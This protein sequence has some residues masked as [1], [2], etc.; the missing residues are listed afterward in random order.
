MFTKHLR[1]LYGFFENHRDIIF[2]LM[3]RVFFVLFIFAVLCAMPQHAFAARLFLSP[4]SQTI[5]P[6]QTISVSVILSSADQA[7]NAVSGTISFPT[8]KFQVVSAS[9][10]GSV[11]SLWVEEPTYSNSAGT[12]NFQGIVPNPGYQGSRGNVLTI[13]FRATNAGPASISFDQASVLAND[14]SGTDI[15]SDKQGANFTISGATP[16]EDTKPVVTPK[17]TGVPDAPIVSSKSHPSTTKWYSATTADFY[18]DMPEDVTAVRY[19]LD[20]NSKVTPSTNGKAGDEKVSFD[21]VDEGVWFFNIQFKN[22][23]GWGSIGSFRIR[24][25]TTPPT[26]P[27]FTLIDNSSDRKSP[28]ITIRS[29]DELSG[30]S[31]YRVKLG[32]NKYE[33][34]A[35]SDDTGEMVVPAKKPGEQTVIVEAY[36]QAGNKS[37]AA[38]ELNVVTMDAPTITDAPKI[39]EKGQDLV[40]HGTTYPDMEVRVYMVGSDGKEVF[41]STRSGSAGDFTLIWKDNLADGSYKV[42]AI[43]VNS[44]GVESLPSDDRN[45]SVHPSI[46]F[47]IGSFVVTVG[48]FVMFMIVVLIGIIYAA[49][50]LWKHFHKF[51]KGLGRE[52]DEIDRS[53][54]TAFN[55]L[56]DEIRLE[57]RALEKAK[58]KRKLTREEERIVDK[59]SADVDDA[60]R[61]IEKQIR[62]VKRKTD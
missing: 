20:K 40:I 62:D 30:I 46:L 41:E 14:G 1:L 22:A 26:T 19:S 48:S 50:T 36:D 51:R 39:L 9:K 38:K 33:T 8:N 56:K 23:K 7:S 60:E 3:K 21:D 10:A 57:V 53:V 42:Y 35:V 29:T 59:F 4:A 25:D 58:T 47:R 6:G 45:I 55:M 34:Y 54:H 15:L 16:T 37:I 49:M 61:F 24:V 32:D 11:L 27:D 44:Y 12:I 5:A 31:Y 17:S 13:V 52:M 43:A 2:R 28:I 18:W